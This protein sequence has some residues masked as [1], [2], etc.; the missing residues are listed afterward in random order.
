MFN[1]QDMQDLK[2][3]IGYLKDR[4]FELEQKQTVYLPIA[5]STSFTV[6]GVRRTIIVPAGE[7]VELIIKHL[8]IEYAYP[9]HTNAKL[10]KQIKKKTVTVTTEITNAKSKVRKK[11]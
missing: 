5:G 4:V 7:A 10:I 9:V 3:E 11:R 6:P 2:K 8:K 1:R